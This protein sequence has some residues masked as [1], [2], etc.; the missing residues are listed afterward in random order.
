MGKGHVFAVIIIMCTSFRTA[1]R[2][3]ARSGGQG[4]G[5]RENATATAFPASDLYP[6]QHHK[7]IDSQRPV[8]TAHTHTHI[9]RVCRVAYL[10]HTLKLLLTR[11]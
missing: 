5:E 8:I 1:Y 11:K 3:T 2:V 6:L 9:R 10:W 4:E 7:P